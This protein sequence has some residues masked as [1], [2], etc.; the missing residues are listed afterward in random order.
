MQPLRLGSCDVCVF[1]LE[2]DYKTLG[3]LWRKQ[4]TRMA[5]KVNVKIQAGKKT[6]DRQPEVEQQRETPGEG[7]GK[8]GA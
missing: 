2:N 3:L 1:N 8:G 4:D 6:K 7:E 5:G